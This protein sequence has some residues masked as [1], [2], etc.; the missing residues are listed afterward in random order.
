MH[1]VDLVRLADS[2]EEGFA[3]E[4]DLLEQ[5]PTGQTVAIDHL[6]K[7]G[8]PAFEASKL[9]LVRDALDVQHRT[10]VLVS[11]VRPR[12]LVARIA[13]ASAAESAAV[14]R[15]WTALLR[16]FT[17]LDGVRFNGPATVT[18]VVSGAAT[19]DPA[20]DAAS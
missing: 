17:V 15:S 19:A 9:E 3:K 18:A 13:D 16:R 10:V 11:G 20:V 8:S 2:G 5:L 4:R 12:S 6:E 14:E 1:V 7:R